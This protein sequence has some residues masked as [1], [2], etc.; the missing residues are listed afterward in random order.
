M[1][2]GVE[3]FKVLSLSDYMI[4]IDNPVIVLCSDWFICGLGETPV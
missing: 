4:F 3:S 2:L 1:F